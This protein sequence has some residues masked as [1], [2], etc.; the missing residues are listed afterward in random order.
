MFVY[1]DRDGVFGILLVVAIQD[2]LVLSFHGE[3]ARVFDTIPF[4]TDAGKFGAFPILGDAV[5]RLEYILQVASMAVANANNSK[6]VKD[7]YKEYG[8]PFMAPK[9]RGDG[10]LVLASCTKALFRELV[11]NHVSLR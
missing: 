4:E 8:A 1:D 11:G 5:M 2:V 3:A 6:V 7:E 9:T 10:G